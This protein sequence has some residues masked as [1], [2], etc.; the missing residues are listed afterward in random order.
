MTDFW[1]RFQKKSFS[2]SLKNDNLTRY[3]HYALPWF[4]R[5]TFPL[6]YK[7]PLIS[8]LKRHACVWGDWPG[9]MPSSTR[10]SREGYWCVPRS[11]TVTAWI[12]DRPKKSH[13]IFY[14]SQAL[15]CLCCKERWTCCPN[16]FFFRYLLKQRGKKGKNPR[17]LVG[18]NFK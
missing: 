17:L 4:I 9:G 13:T 5:T 3:E 10:R 8:S 2:V 16:L 1:K 18:L 14:S 7:T 6:F 11:T 15:L 12:C